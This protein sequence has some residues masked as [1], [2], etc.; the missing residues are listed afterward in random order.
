MNEPLRQV[1]P[2][3]V[4]IADDDRE[5]CRACGELPVSYPDTM[6]CRRCERNIQE[7]RLERE[8]NR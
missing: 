6:H 4:V 2:D 1:S 8:S 7:D 5:M 3:R